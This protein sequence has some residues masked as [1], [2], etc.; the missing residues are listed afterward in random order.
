MLKISL[1]YSEC[2]SRLKQQN[3]QCSKKKKKKKKKYKVFDIFNE[4]INIVSKHY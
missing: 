4:L 3:Q 1:S 2:C